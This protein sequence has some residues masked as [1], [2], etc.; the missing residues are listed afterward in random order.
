MALTAL[1]WWIDRW[2]KSTAYTDMTA[3][4]QGCY[5]NLLDEA[6]LRK[7]PL[8]NNNRILAKASGDPRAWKR[9]RKIVLSRFIL[10]PDGY[11][12][13]TLDDI[14]SK[15]SQI[16]EKRA[17]AGKNGAIQRWQTHSKKNGKRYASGS[18]SGSVLKKKSRNRICP[19]TPTCATWSSCTSLILEDGR[20]EK[21]GKG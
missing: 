18:G 11:R 10:G 21:A 4:A 1:W 8:P 9:V 2:R 13:E 14:F 17:L 6:W 19:H 20:K 16:R 7:G 5:R 12:N 15:V 3:A